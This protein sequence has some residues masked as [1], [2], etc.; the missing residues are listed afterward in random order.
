MNRIFSESRHDLL[1][2]ILLFMLA[3]AL[4]LLCAWLVLKVRP[5]D[6]PENSLFSWY[7]PAPP[8]GCQFTV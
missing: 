2:N 6:P 4:G 3:L 7:Q 5:A 8:Y 1:T